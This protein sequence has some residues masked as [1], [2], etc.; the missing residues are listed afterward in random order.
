MDTLIQEAPTENAVPTDF[1]GEW[2]RKGTL[3]SLILDAGQTLNWPEYELK[4]AAHS[5]Y[6]FRRLVM[7]TV[8][9]YSYATGVY[10]SRNIA[11]RIS[12]DKIL[13]F[14]CAGTY[15]TWRELRD[16]SRQ[17]RHLIRQCLIQTYNTAR[18]YGLGTAAGYPGDGEPA[19]LKGIL[20]RAR[21]DFELQLAEEAEEQIEEAGHWDAVALEK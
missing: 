19:N 14:L 11:S 1:L 3:L 9:T 20:D 16:F 8:V 15:P 18:E 4:L 21:V 2:I 7:L 17:N 12:R 6:A 13:Q 10:G 5:G